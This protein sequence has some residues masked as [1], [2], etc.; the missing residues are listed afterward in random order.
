M[1]VAAI[2]DVHNKLSK[3]EVPECDVLIIAGDLTMM[4]YE[5]EVEKFNDAL[6]K[7]RAHANAVVVIAGNHDFGLEREPARYEAMLTNADHYLRDSAVVIGGVKFYGSPW[8]P[9]FHSWAFNL[10]RGPDIK[11]KWD[12]IPADT[13]VLVTHGPPRGILDMCPS[14]EKV[15]CD[16]L[17]EAVLRVKPAYHVFGHIHHANGLQHFMGTTFIN[18]STCDERYRPT[19][20][21][22]TFDVE[23]R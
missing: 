10:Q 17:L 2:S 7:A 15:G 21:P 23:P 13:D 3:V 19:N 18:A 1:R 20:R 4:G 16:D 12:L 11:A 6:V 14:G 22:V 9:W 5:W 8:Q